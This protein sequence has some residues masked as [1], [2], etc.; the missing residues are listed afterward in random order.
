MNNDEKTE[1]YYINLNPKC[2]PQLGKRGLYNKF[3][4]EPYLNEMK[5][6]ILWI[7]NFS[8]GENSIQTIANKAN[9]ELELIKKTCKLLEKEK[10]IKKI[11]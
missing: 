1:E 10:L 9:L 4:G 8:D 6:A 11:N 5:S 3:G 7:L 2:E